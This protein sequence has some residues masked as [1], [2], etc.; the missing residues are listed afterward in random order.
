MYTIYN[1]IKPSQCINHNKTL[2]IY[3]D[4]TIK[5]SGDAVLDLL[6]VGSIHSLTYINTYTYILIYQKKLIHLS[7]YT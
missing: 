1:T 5:P 6:Q 2:Q 7:I 3:T 4:N